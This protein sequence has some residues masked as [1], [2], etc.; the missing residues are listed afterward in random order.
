MRQINLLPWREEQRQERQ[1]NFLILMAATALVA[2]GIVFGVKSYFDAQ[3]EGQNAR[4]TYLRNEI[5]KLDRQIA[6]IDELDEVRQRL[7]DRKDVIETLQSNRTLMV[8][9]FEQLVTTVPEGIRLLTVQQ[10]GDQLTIDGTA[11]SSAR[12]STYLRNLEASEFL[13]DPTLRIVEAEAEE[14]DRE[15]PYR[16]A[17]NVRLAAPSSDESEEVVAP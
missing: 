11:Q 12:V 13:H 14:T 15:L 16:F 17:V 9:L 2:A 3:I 7:I 8:H 6:R 1:K 10:A 4:N 5:A